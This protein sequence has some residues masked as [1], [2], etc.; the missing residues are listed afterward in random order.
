MGGKRHK[1]GEI[2]EYEGNTLKVQNRGQRDKR[3]EALAAKPEMT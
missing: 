1:E 3:A 2:A